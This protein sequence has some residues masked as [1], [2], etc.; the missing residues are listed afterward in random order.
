MVNIH[1]IIHPQCS[2]P[3]SQHFY[4]HT[5]ELF[6]ALSLTSASSLPISRRVYREDNYL[7]AL[8]DYTLYLRNFLKD[9]RV[10][11]VMPTSEAACNTICN[12]IDFLRAN[13]IVEIGAGSGTITRHLLRRMDNEAQLHVIET[14]MGLL[15]QLRRGLRD[16]RLHH[17]HND[18]RNIAD[19]CAEK[20][21][22][23][24]VII[25][26]IPLTYMKGG[27]LSLYMQNLLSSISAH[28]KLIIY[29]A[30]FPPVCFAARARRYLKSCFK[31]VSSE[32]VYSN[33]PPLIVLG[34]RPRIEL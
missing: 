3:S 9:S 11:A 2:F 29:Q 21:I 26:G 5:E 25:S 8:A 19:I 28:G 30:W 6:M 32:V 14:N 4:N 16:S 23:P 12:Q 20:Q 24:D 18:G 17:Y 34:A 7:S 1:S 15:K 22:K 13:T 33:L 31:E 27:E 10:A